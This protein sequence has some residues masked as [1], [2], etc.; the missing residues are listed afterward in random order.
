[1]EI[2]RMAMGGLDGQ[3]WKEQML[4]SGADQRQQVEQ[5]AAEFEGVLLRQFLDSA[6]KPMDGE[7]GMFGG[8]SSPMY[9][10]MVKDTL[11]SAITKDGSLGFS[12]VLQAQ[13]FPHDKPLAPNK[14]S[15][16]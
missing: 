14:T 8:K 2:S 15:N 7:S 6:L 10:Q 3:N 5:L 16:E 12:S 13:L 4:T 11:A 1:M 9:E